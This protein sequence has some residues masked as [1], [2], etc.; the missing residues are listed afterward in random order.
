MK[1]VILN[2]FLIINDDNLI[3]KIGAVAHEMDGDDNDKMSYLGVS[4]EKD[5]K[6]IKIF[7]LPKNFHVVDVERNIRKERCISYG[8]FCELSRV[9]DERIFEEI[10]EYYKA[11]QSPLRCITPVKNGKITYEGRERK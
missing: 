7:E 1:E 5:L 2:L 4:V 11:P 3:E 9:G 8:T 10:Y 6:N